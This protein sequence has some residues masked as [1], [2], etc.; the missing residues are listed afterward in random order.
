MVPSNEIEN[1]KQLSVGRK[2]IGQ[3]IVH[4]EETFIQYSC[5]FL[6]WMGLRIWC[7]NLEEPVDSL[8]NSACRIAAISTFRQVAAAGAYDYMSINKTY[9]KEIDLLHQ[10]YNHYVHH[11][12]LER[13]TKETKESG[14]FGAEEE[15]KAIQKAR[16]RVSFFFLF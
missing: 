12:M 15:K 13:Y 3:G 7:P 11:H 4:V 14:K 9:L 1:F 16:E 6:A 5:S 10:C 2:N 8:L